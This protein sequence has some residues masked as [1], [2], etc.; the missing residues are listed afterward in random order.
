MSEKITTSKLYKYVST[1]RILEILQDQRL[2]LNDGTNFNDPFELIEMD[3]HSSE[4]KHIPG[5]HIL[6]LS[7]GNLNKLIWSHYTDSHKGVCLTVEVPRKLL[8]P[9]HYSS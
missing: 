8:Y 3:Q 4:V 5:L 1:E 6:C 7:K 9:V 2:Y